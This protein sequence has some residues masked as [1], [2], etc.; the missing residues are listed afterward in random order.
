MAIATFPAGIL[1]KLILCIPSL[2]LKKKKKKKKTIFNM[3][4]KATYSMY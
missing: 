4:A 3:H 2:D 1:G